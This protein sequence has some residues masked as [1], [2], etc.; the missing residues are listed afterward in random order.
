MED[1]RVS[2]IMQREV[3][4]VGPDTS[5]RELADLLSKH[6][7]S[8]VPVVDEGQRV[9]GM[10]SEADVILQDADLH[11]PHYIQFLDSIIYLESFSKFRE[12]Y[13]KAFGFKVSEIMSQEV[14]AI[15]PEASVREAATL[16]ADN[17]VNRLPVTQARKLVG[18]VTR[19]D[20]VQAI[21][22]SKA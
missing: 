15:S 8:G 1:L 20:I 12:R 6:K 4:T 9:I 10:V 3:I 11:F 5:V 16:M 17:K 21:A 7:I 13:R 19:G 22:E 18:I 14:I 2:E